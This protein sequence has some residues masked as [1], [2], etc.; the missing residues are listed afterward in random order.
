[1]GAQR[2]QKMFNTYINDNVTSPYPF[3]GGSKLPF[4]LGCILGMGLCLKGPE[5]GHPVYASSVTITKTSVHV[6]LCRDAEIVATLN[7][8]TDGDTDTILQTEAYPSVSGYLLLGSLDGVVPAS[9]S[10]VFYIDPSCVVY[11][12]EAVYTYH[13]EIEINN[14]IYLLGSSLDINASGLLQLDAVGQLEGTPSSASMPLTS[15]DTLDTSDR[16]LSINGMSVGE[17]SEHKTLTIGTSCSSAI[18]FTA[19]ELGTSFVVLSA[20]GSQKFPNCYS[21]DTDDALA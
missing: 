20:H 6:V 21:A 2:S 5:T 16:V 4:P 19:M 11:L 17:G 8:A 18:T 1:M 3:F 14:N 13:T 12:P 15:A 7:A 9:Y 10:G